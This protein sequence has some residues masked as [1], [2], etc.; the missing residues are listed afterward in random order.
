MAYL[1]D[2]TYQEMSSLA[3]QNLKPGDTLKP[4]SDVVWKVVEPEGAK[5][6]AKVSGFD[7]VVFYNEQS[8]E[9]VIGY[10]G[11]EPQWGDQDQ[12]INRVMDMETDFSDVVM[13]K[14]KYIEESINSPV[15]TAILDSPLVLLNN[16]VEY[17][18][19]QFHQAEALYEAV[20]EQYPN[21]RISATGHSL[22]GALAQFVAARNDISGV[23]FSAP[24]VTNLLSDDLLEKVNNGDFD[25]Q[26]INYVNPSDSVGAGFI[27][28]YERHIGSTYYIGSDFQT[29]NQSYD[30]IKIPVQIS[31]LPFSP[32][33]DFPGSWGPGQI[34]RAIDSFS[35]K[36]G[37]SYHSL[38]N[39]TFDSDGNI[40]N[41]LIDQQTGE[42]VDGSPRWSNY[43][44]AVAAWENLMNRG[45]DFF[46]SL[47]DKF[48]PTMALLA[49]STIQLE[50]EVLK[51][52]SQKIS[53]HVQEFERELPGTL[54]SIQ[55]L[56]DS[57]HSRSLQP[58]VQR[59][60]NELNQFIRWYASTASDIAG[61][62][63]KKADDFI[64]AD[65]GQNPTR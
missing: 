6:H 23:T 9:V 40:N 60:T 49:G 33:I 54:R 19:N 48:L 22:G 25:K 61:F 4:L 32:T 18:N 31:S 5:L 38:E 63:N 58:I 21:A 57:S 52:S 20:K 36:D 62:I 47:M 30:D 7:A 65:Q 28:E 46:H 35:S 50:P 59:T 39:Y 43:T 11:T 15:T 13:G 14:Y 42:K 29:A 17:K 53:Q 26:I 55:R 37:I 2:K 12:T 3:Y 45:S 64:Q 51:A 1:N 10:R 34:M 8:N 27:S 41:T 44:E 56:L 16:Y 24:S